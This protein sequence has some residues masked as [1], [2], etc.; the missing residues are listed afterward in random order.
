MPTKRYGRFKVKKIKK[1][2]ISAVLALSMG[3]T[4]MPTD[5][6]GFRAYATNE[7]ESGTANQRT[8][9]KYVTMLGTTDD[10]SFG[11]A[12]I[13]SGLTDPTGPYYSTGL[14]YGCV[15]D[16]TFGTTIYWQIATGKQSPGAD[17]D[18]NLFDRKTMYCVD[19]HTGDMSRNVFN[20]GFSKGLLKL[21]EDGDL[22]DLM[23]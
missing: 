3:M 12:I 21:D 1:R 10:P 20:N 18:Y 22:V 6:T 4:L 7:A 9:G 23:I 2:M 19:K 15:N 8:N 17:F 5:F 13:N 11:S 14:S 16:A